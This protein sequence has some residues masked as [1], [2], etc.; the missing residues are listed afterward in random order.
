MQKFNVT[1]YQRDYIDAPSILTVDHTSLSGQ[2]AYQIL[3]SSTIGAPDSP[4]ATHF[5]YELK[6]PQGIIPEQPWHTAKIQVPITP[7]N[8][9]VHH[10]IFYML[11]SGIP[12]QVS[13]SNLR[14]WRYCF[15]AIFKRKPPERRYGI[16]GIADS[17]YFTEN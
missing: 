14:V 5:L 1:D 6:T 15:T 4:E 10:T 2:P 16:K 11:S 8:K 17:V 9:A 12:V 13:F 3:Y 7:L